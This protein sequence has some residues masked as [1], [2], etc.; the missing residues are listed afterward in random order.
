MAV[1]KPVAAPN[2]VQTKTLPLGKNMVKFTTQP[3][4]TYP[5]K[6]V[7]SVCKPTPTLGTID[8]QDKGEIAVLAD[9]D[10]TTLT[11]DEIG[12]LFPRYLLRRTRT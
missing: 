7:T 8:V 6:T 1:A 5:T 3:T 10:E 2:L 9:D 4:S 11:E 12:N